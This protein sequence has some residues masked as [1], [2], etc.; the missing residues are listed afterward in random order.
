VSNDVIKVAHIRFCKDK[1]TQYVP[2]SYIKK[3]H[4]KNINDFKTKD[5]YDVL[6][7]DDVDGSA[8][9]FKA[10]ILK[11]GGNLMNFN[12]YFCVFL[13]VYLIQYT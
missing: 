5:L 1:K 2:I 12:L 3:F 9:K 11:L 8:K 6:W 10:Q 13:L 4:P 7:I